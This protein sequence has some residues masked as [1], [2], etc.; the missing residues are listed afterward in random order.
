MCLRT[1][2][3]LRH[4][5]ARRFGR[6]AFELDDA[7]NEAESPLAPTGPDTQ[8]DREDAITTKTDMTA[9]FQFHS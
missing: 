3:I 5:D 4:V 7:F 9:I 6:S 8:P 1:E 2:W